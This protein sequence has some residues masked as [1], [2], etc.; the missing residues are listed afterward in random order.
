MVKIS[1]FKKNDGALLVI[2][3]TPKEKLIGEVYS[4]GVEKRGKWDQRATFEDQEATDMDDSIIELPNKSLSHYTYTNSSGQEYI[5]E[6]KLSQD[7]KEQVE[8]MDW[9]N[10]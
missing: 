4:N 3:K 8:W 1:M 7:I 10:R 6:E 2:Y 5:D 9:L